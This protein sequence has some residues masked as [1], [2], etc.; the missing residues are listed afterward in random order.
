M[1]RIKEQ[2]D[3]GGTIKAFLKEKGLKQCEVADKAKLNK[4]FL[5]EI[6]SGKKNPMINTLSRI[7]KAMDVSTNY[8]LIASFKVHKDREAE[9]RELLY[10]LKPLIMALE[11]KAESEESE[12]E[13]ASELLDATEAHVLVMAKWAHKYG[14]KKYQDKQLGKLV[15]EL[16]NSF[17]HEGTKS[18]IEKFKDCC[19]ELK[20]YLDKAASK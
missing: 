7:C 1:G 16:H 17:F 3:F 19:R 9:K 14:D 6:I 10:K 20:D 2:Y 15:N 18:D 13:I 12:L 11:N 4:G 8:F 5:S